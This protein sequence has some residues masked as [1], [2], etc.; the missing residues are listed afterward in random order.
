MVSPLSLNQPGSQESDNKV[1]VLGEFFPQ[2]DIR[3]ELLVRLQGKLQTTLD[4]QQLLEIFFDEIQSSILLDGL[5]YSH[6][7]SE[8][9]TLVGD[10]G[11]HSVRYHLQT[12]SDSMGELVLYRKTRFREYELANLEGMLTTLVF[13]MRNALNYHQAL[14]AAYKDPL[15]GAGNRAAMER[16][17]LREIELSKRTTNPLTVLML[18]LDHFKKINDQYGHTVGDKVLKDAVTHIQKATR[19]TDLCFRYGGEEFL[20]LLSNT[21]TDAGRII[22]ERIR[23]EIE[24]L[25]LITDAGTVQITASIGCATLKAD[26]NLE[27]LISRADNLLYKAKNAG[28][29]QILG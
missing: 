13:P 9:N 11:R 22:A 15:T 29:N 7:T 27:Q 12:Q 10:K 19:Q 1:S 5:G 23:K 4:T 17:L 2:P 21:H 6:Q 20:I 28:R 14:A 24:S 25:K 26:D 18:D 16:T 3:P 8:L